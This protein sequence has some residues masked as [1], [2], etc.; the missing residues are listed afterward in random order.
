[1][2]LTNKWR[3]VATTGAGVAAAA[4]LACTAC[5]LPLI[6]PIAASL[7]A[8]VGAYCLDDVINPWFVSV[9]AGIAFVSIFGWLSYLRRRSRLRA[10][11]GTCGCQ[12][13]RGSN[14]ASS[15]ESVMNVSKP[16]PIACTLSAA[17]F[18][19]RA[20]WLRDLTSRALLSHQ[21]DELRLHL[22]YRL[23]AAA[24]VDKMVFQEREC[25]GFLSYTVRRTAVSIDVT[26]TAL[27]DVGADAQIL[28]SHLLPG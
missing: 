10:G 9:V 2:T 3:N 8:G 25:C 22:S 14:A 6:A 13:E 24:D 21:L 28:F 16:A 15:A 5:C 23:E 27:L 12:G 19:E 20:D 11:K 18:K 26:V 1:M 7:L 4:G 17:N